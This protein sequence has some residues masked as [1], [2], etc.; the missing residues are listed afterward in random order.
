MT[1]LGVLVSG[2]GSNL[3]A[4]LEACASGAIDGS[5]AIVAANRECPAL[6]IARDAGVEQVRAFSLSDYG[7]AAERDG[8]MTGALQS[9]RVEL[10]V[11]AGYNRV[12]DDVLVRA[13]EGRIVN[14]HPSLLPEFGGT[15]EAIRQAFEAG[16]PE[17][18][19]TVHLIDP[20]TVDAGTILAQERIPI[21]PGD[22]LPTLEAK[23]HAAEHRLLPA[24]I[25]AVIEGR[26]VKQA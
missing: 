14:V 10:V 7:S 18:G 19:V 8:A 13:F 22:S 21:E 1:R 20:G 24:T 3:R 9:A 5:V 4:I 11:C 26:L 25:Q 17:T 6:E 23:V 2:R 16:V 12:L 15:M